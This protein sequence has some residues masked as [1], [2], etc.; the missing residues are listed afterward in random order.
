MTSA[1]EFRCEKQPTASHSDTALRIPR[2]NPRDQNR[3]RGFGRST[4]G[5]HAPGC[6]MMPRHQFV[7]LTVHG[8]LLAGRRSMCSPNLT[9]SLHVKRKA[10]Q[11]TARPGQPAPP[12]SPRLSPSPARWIADS[13]RAGSPNATA[14]SESCRSR[15]R[16][17]A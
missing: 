8:A 7:W 2:M 16:S 6:C 4:G 13:G 17:A 12:K 9:P 10:G 15:G 3:A 5:G 11:N 1:Q 14:S